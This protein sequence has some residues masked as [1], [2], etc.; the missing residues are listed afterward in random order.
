[1]IEALLWIT[2]V[3]GIPTAFAIATMFVGARADRRAD[4]F[5]GDQWP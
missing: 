3:V 4:D 2:I 5:H 1:M